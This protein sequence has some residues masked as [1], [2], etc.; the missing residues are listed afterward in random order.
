MFRGRYSVLT[1]VSEGKGHRK[2]E[3]ERL[4]AFIAKE[5]EE[6]STGFPFFTQISKLFR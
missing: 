3:K 5:N 4:N 1:V 6:L 2:S